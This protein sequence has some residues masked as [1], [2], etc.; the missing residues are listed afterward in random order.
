MIFILIYKVRFGTLVQ[1]K[2]PHDQGRCENNMIL[3]VR[4]V[5]F[6][7]KCCYFPYIATQKRVSVDKFKIHKKFVH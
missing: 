4:R 2:E 6:Q 7:F 5:F 3:E 1:C